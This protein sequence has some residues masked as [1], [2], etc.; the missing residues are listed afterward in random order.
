MLFCFQN[1][2][3]RINIILAFRLQAHHHISVHGDKATIA[4]VTKTGIISFFDQPLHGLVVQSQIENSIHH[5]GH[6]SAG[7]GAHRN[8][9]G[10]LGITKFRFH[11]FFHILQG[12]LQFLFQ[13][14]WIF[15]I[16][17]IIVR[18]NFGRDG[19]TRRD[20]YA[21]VGHLGQVSALT[22]QEIFHIF[23]S[24]R[25]SGAEEIDIFVCHK[26]NLLR[27]ELNVQIAETS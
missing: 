24:F 25:F 21:Y 1:F 2:L 12:I 4:I 26:N 27:S 3:K 15:I 16:I 6:G 22:T 8:Q 17:I 18:A 19:K 14:G 20:R 23:C 5:S 9:Q 10:V 13:T 11:Y 7:S